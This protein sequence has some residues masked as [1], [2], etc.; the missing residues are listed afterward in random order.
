VKITR[1]TYLYLPQELP[2]AKVLIMVKAYPQPSGKYEE[3]VCTAGL[4]NGET[5]IRIYP[6]PYRFLSNNRQYPKYSWVKLNLVRN[7]SDF[8]PESYKL[9]QGLDEEFRV[10]SRVGTKDAWAARKSYVL[11]EVFTSMEDL[12]A[13]AKSD[14]KK[15]LA[16]VKPSEVTDFKIEEVD[17]QWK[18]KWIDQSKQSTFFELDDTGKV[19]ERKLIPKLPYKYSYEFLTEGD[20]DPRRMKIEDWEIGALFWNCLRQSN[21]N[22]DLANDLVRQKYFNEFVNDKDLY[23][24]VGTTKRFHNIAKNPFMIIGVFYPP[25]SSQLPLL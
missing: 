6:V 22:E 2:Q 15:S 1:G 18:D 12:I 16:T 8:R 17:R 7:T 3:L 10:L 5:W 25:K 13:L 20:S 11:E 24:F 14:Q 23:F 9:R 21:G 19:E 4:L